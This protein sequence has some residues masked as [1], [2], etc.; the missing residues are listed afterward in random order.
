[1]LA[2]VLGGT[3]GDFLAVFAP[4]I[5]PYAVTAG[6]GVACDREDF[7]DG[8]SAKGMQSLA[9]HIVGDVERRTLFNDIECGAVTLQ[10]ALAGAEGL[11]LPAVLII[12][13]IP[14]L[15]RFYI[16]DGLSAQTSDREDKDNEKQ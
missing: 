4:G 7:T 1:M 8:C 15:C 10:L 9:A 11:D 12:D 13:I 16:A 5:D 6:E 2:L 3:G 14:C